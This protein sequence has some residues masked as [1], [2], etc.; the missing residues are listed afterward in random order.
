[1][2]NVFN[3]DSDLDSK[4]RVICGFRFLGRFADSDNP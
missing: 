3:S 1:M 2:D 4:I